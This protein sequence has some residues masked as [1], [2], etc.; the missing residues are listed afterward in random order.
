MWERRYGLLRPQRTEGGFRLYSDADQERVVLMQRG[1][2]EGLPASLAARRV[3]AETGAAEAPPLA[4]APPSIVR[5]LAE[6]LDRFDESA[7][8]A[9]LDGALATLS[10]EAFLADVILPYL[11]ALGSRW[12][13]SEISIA[14][15]HFA[16]SI[17]RGRLLGLSRGWGTG[18]GPRALLACPPGE[19]HD[20]G[21]ICFGL[22][23]RAHGWRVVLLGPNT[24]IDTIQDAASTLLP[25]FV[26]VSS[27]SIEAVG[28]VI[29][30]LRRLGGTHQLAIAGPGVTADQAAHANALHLAESPTVAAR[31][32]IAHVAPAAPG[33]PEG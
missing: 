33:S 9:I 25:S 20:L 19:L 6:A 15:E 26:V 7:A 17:V 1:I 4:V 18:A 3:G 29:D 5:H 24:P 2:A 31:R 11:Q 32:V 28:A 16:T 27:M 14:Q 10:L 13:R 30:D 12:E 21:L 23:L 8:N 22:T